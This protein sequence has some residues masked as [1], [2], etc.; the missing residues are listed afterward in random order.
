MSNQPL[1]PNTTRNIIIAALVVV[2]IPGLFTGFWLILNPSGPTFSFVKTDQFTVA[3]AIFGGTSSNA[4]NYINMTIQNTGASAW[5]LTKT[6]QVNDIN[7]TVSSTYGLTCANGAS[8]T[9]KIANVNWISGNEYSMVLLDTTGNKFTYEATA[10]PG[11]HSPDPNPNPNNIPSVP[12]PSSADSLPLWLITSLIDIILVEALLG[13]VFVEVIVLHRRY[14]RHE[15]SASADPPK[16]LSIFKSRNFTFA[17]L[18]ILLILMILVALLAF[19]LV[20][21]YLNPPLTFS[22]ILARA[23][24]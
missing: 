13:V 22:W 11:G 18:E 7:H 14:S 3:E 6:A 5:T 8:I 17:V 4:T 10:N 21:S 24:L 23:P 12:S 15:V 20:W 2:M 9:V 16:P 1:N 19:W